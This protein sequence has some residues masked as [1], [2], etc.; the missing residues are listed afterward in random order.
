VTSSRTNRTT[1]LRRPGWLRRSPP[2]LTSPAN[3][4]S[5]PPSRAERWREITRLIRRHRRWL[6][7]GCLGL[8]VAIAVSTLAPQPA[9]GEF[10]VTAARDLQPGVTLT[11]ADL[12]Q[13]RFT[14]AQLPAGAIAQPAA[15]I[16]RRLGSAIRRGEPLTDVRLD[17]AGALASP[18]NGLVAMPIRLADTR[19]AEL[20]QPGMRVDVLA[21][22]ATSAE[23]GAASSIEPAVVVALGVTV[24]AVPNP[25]AATGLA[26]SDTDPLSQDGALVVLATTPEQARLLA[27]AQVSDR[28]SAVSLG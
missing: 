17:D 14:T 15:A 22:S 8:G 27:Q 19:A 13:V 23:L 3:R 11:A 5:S 4:R 20:L 25:A 6:S 24:V 10:I 2:V 7:A 1:R 26:A 18:G 28:L 9:S 12:R 16:G 21:A